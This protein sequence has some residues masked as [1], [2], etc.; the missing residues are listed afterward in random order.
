[1]AD[2]ILPGGN[3][4]VGAPKS[5]VETFGQQHIRPGRQIRGMIGT[6]FMCRQEESVDENHLLGRIDR[7]TGQ[8][9]IIGLANLDIKI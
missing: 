9:Y 7:I 2:E 3:E 6:F 8:R 5:I 4:V 1:M